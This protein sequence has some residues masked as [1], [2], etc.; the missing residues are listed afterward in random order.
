MYRVIYDAINDVETA[1][2]GMLAP[3]FKEVIQ[4]KV[5]IRKVYD[6]SKGIFAGCYVL[7][8]KV[9]N[10][11][12]VRL[13]RENIVLHEGKVDSLRRFKDDVKEVATGYEC[14]IVLAK[15]REIHEG[16]VLEVF[17]MEEIAR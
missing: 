3:R 14:G 10:Q 16:D 2:K 6:T 5:E 8:G 9:T 12:S 11:S 7:E 15:F 17:I 1:I 13:V 4:G